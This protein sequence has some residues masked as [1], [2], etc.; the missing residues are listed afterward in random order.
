MSEAWTPLARAAGVLLGALGIVLGG[1]GLDD[2]R[3]VARLNVE[4]PTGYDIAIEVSDADGASWTAV[5]NADQRCTTTFELVADRGGQWRVRFRAQGSDGG[6]IMLR[7]SE[8]EQAGWTI[9]VPSEVSTTLERA[10]A[11]LPP[12]RECR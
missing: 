10:G 9:H 2:A 8:I 1:C 6:E 3:T 5:G 4:N 12:P 11:P 7:R